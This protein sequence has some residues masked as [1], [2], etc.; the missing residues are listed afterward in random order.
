MSSLKNAIN[1]AKAMA[2]KCRGLGFDV[3]SKFNVTLREILE[4]LEEVSETW[5]ADASEIVLFYAGHG[6]SI[7]KCFHLLLANSSKWLL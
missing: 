3:L 2:D 6:V 4:F 5:K 1:D 7:G